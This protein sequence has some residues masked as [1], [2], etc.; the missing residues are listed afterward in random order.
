M[1]LCATISRVGP[2]DGYRVI[3]LCQIVSGPFACMQLADQGAEVIKVEAP[4]GGDLIRLAALSPGGF[5][6]LFANCNRGKKSVAIDL[7]TEAGRDIVRALIATADVVV[8]NYR[9]GTLDRFGLGAA[10]ALEINP[11]VIYVSIT[12]YGSTGPYADRKVYDPVIQGVT[13]FV[14]TQMNPQIPFNDVVRNIVCDKA[15]ALTVAQ[16]V[17]AALL[18][19]ERGRARGQHIEV[20]MLEAGLAFFWPDGMMNRTML[21]DVD[22]PSKPTLGQVM[23]VT[24]TADGQLVYFA[25]TQDDLFGVLRAV[26]RADLVSDLRFSTMS[27]R[28]KHLGELGELLVAAFEQQPTA[29]V[30]SRLIAEQVAAGPVNS[31]DDLLVD[32]QIQHN[33]SIV[34][35]EHATAGTIRQTVAPARFSHTVSKSTNHVPGL[36]EHND[37][38]LTGLGYDAER[39]GALRESGVL[40]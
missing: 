34:E 27:E 11:D 21:I 24:N 9:P 39:I 20:S 6:G 17:T 38:V 1:P 22:G 33:G 7:R 2:L 36:G 12:G 25:N 26:G 28:V 32:P 18:A 40:G 37:Q 5:S 31:L 35:W 10:E 4:G 19:R 16:A 3:E 8:Q 13:G 23:S 15:T 14:A 29:K 30:L